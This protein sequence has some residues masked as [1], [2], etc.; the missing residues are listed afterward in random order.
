MGDRD[1]SYAKYLSHHAQDVACGLACRT[2]L[3][4]CWRIVHMYAFCR[5]PGC[6]LAPG[7]RRVYVRMSAPGAIVRTS[8]PWALRSQGL[9]ARGT[10]LDRALIRVLRQLGAAGPLHP[11][12][13]LRRGLLG[14]DTAE[15]TIQGS[16]EY[17]A[18]SSAGGE[19]CDFSR[20][21][22][23][24]G[25]VRP[26]GATRTPGP[27]GPSA[28]LARLLRLFGPL[29]RIRASA[30]RQGHA[31]GQGARAAPAGRSER[32]LTPGVY[33]RAAEICFV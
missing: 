25:E 13:F 31:R 29:R 18:G 4:R 11:L 8:Q 22:R 6:P 7:H 14:G 30:A 33:L 12:T 26:P 10:R 15:A 2:G 3:L 28:A 19:R 21:G 27:D 24:Q 16:D 17:P 20:E 23:R 32:A 1:W 5:W 9:A